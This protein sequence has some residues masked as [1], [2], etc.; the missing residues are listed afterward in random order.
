MAHARVEIPYGSSNKLIIE[1]G[2]LAKQAGGAVT[3]VTQATWSGIVRIAGGF[4][5]VLGVAGSA[6]AA[7]EHTQRRSLCDLP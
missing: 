5:A 2:K 7:G 4:G 3:E 1:T 6:P